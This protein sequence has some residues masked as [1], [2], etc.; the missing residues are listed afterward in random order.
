MS[1]FEEILSLK[2]AAAIW[3]KEESTIRKAIAAGRLIK[4]E[5]CEKYGKQWVVTVDGM[6]K[7]F[8]KVEG[9]SDYGPWIEYKKSR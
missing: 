2:E 4:G 3:G 9:K 7:A 6:A 8:C 5:E 1:P